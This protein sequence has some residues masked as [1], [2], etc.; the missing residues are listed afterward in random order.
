MLALVFSSGVDTDPAKQGLLVDLFRLTF[1][2]L[3]FVSL[4][5]LA[6]TAHGTSLLNEHAMGVQIL[7]LHGLITLTAATALFIGAAMFEK[8]AARRALRERES[9]FRALTLLSAAT[10]GL[11]V[12]PLLLGVDKPVH[13]MV[14]SVTALRDAIDAKAK[15][16]DDIVKIGRTHMQDATPITLFHRRFVELSGGAQADIVVIPTASQLE[17]TGADY[18]SIFRGLGAGRVE[19]L[20]IIT[21]ADCE[22]PRYVEMLD[23][24]TGIFLTGGNQ[25]KLSTILGGTPVA[26]LPRQSLLRVRLSAAFALPTPLPNVNS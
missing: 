3:L 8:Q 2:F 6:G 22:N 7:V 19:F 1:P 18:M 25:L 16:W 5:A 12:G 21:R 11:L 13:V 10:E 24:A 15:E 17:T 23:R 14:P 20:P 4:T 9:H 26:K